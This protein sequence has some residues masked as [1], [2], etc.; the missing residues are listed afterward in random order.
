MEIVVTK[1]EKFRRVA[2][3]L[4][5]LLRTMNYFDFQTKALDDFLT[6]QQGKTR[7]ELWDVYMN[8]LMPR[9]PNNEAYDPLTRKALHLIA[10]V[11]EENI[12]PEHRQ[13]GSGE[14]FSLERFT[15]GLDAKETED[16]KNGS[17]FACILS[18]GLSVKRIALETNE[19]GDWQN[20][21]WGSVRTFGAKERFELPASHMGEGLYL[22]EETGERFDVHNVRYE[23][24]LSFLS[25]DENHS[26]FSFLIPEET[27][28]ED[29]WDSYDDHD[30]CS[31]C[32][33]GGCPKCDHS[34]FYG[35]R[36]VD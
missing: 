19:N 3:G 28:S 8:G 20:H 33:G 36:V 18:E 10:N 26:L 22:I 27:K 6:P 14:P 21:I 11:V 25:K 31:I 1:K 13:H 32:R 7:D 9:H 35:F 34:G 23:M 16:W 17:P 24:E 15:E 29:E 12:P 4:F 2:S 30:E 5:H